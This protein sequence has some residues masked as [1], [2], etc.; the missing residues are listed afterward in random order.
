MSLRDFLSQM[1]KE[2]EILHIKTEMSKR[3]EISYLLR[4]FDNKGPI[5]LLENLK[6]P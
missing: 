6:G 5:L 2:K 3:F 4:K 1:D